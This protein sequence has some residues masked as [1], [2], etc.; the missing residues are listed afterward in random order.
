MA[1]TILALPVALPMP[2][3]V[4]PAWIRLAEGD[5]I[6]AIAGADH[7]DVAARA[8]VARTLGVPDPAAT[9]TAMAPAVLR[10]DRE[11]RADPQDA[12][13]AFHRTLPAAR[14]DPQWNLVL[15]QATRGASA[16][17]R[18]EPPAS[19]GVCITAG[20]RTI[21]SAPIARPTIAT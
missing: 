20:R 2:L 15:A 11:F 13:V 17:S 9:A 18:P 8:Q 7:L 3:R 12:G 14:T 1:K 16:R 6:V 10:P 4:S 21:A 19:S 5:Q